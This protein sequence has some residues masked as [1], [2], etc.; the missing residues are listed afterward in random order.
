MQFDSRSMSEMVCKPL[1]QFTWN[2]LSAWKGAHCNTMSG[3]VGTV[4]CSLMHRWR[5]Q[6]I[7][8]CIRGGAKE[9]CCGEG[10]QRDSGLRSQRESTSQPNL[11][12]RWCH[13]RHVVRGFV[14]LKLLR[15]PSF[16]A[17]HT[18]AALV[19]SWPSLIALSFLSAFVSFLI[20]TLH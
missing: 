15:P 16:E 1:T 12:Q 5:E 9:H 20:F 13:H 2:T 18:S 7:G 4:G 11:A 17:V 14:A 8:A 19:D 6:D 3:F 10:K